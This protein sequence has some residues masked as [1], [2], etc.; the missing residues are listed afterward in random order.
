M[1]LKLMNASAPGDDASAA[2]DDRRRRADDSRDLAQ[3][4]DL[5]AVVLDAGRLEDEDVRRRAENAIAQLALQARHHRHRD[6]ER[7]ARRP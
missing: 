4:R 1:P 3:R 2:P 5:G 7:H 6:D